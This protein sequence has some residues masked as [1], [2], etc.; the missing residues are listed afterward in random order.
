MCFPSTLTPPKINEERHL[1]QKNI[2]I[3]LHSWGFHV[4]FSRV[5]IS[6]L[7]KNLS[8]VR[9]EEAAPLS[10]TAWDGGDPGE[11]RLKVV[12]PERVDLWHIC[13]SLC[14]YTYYMYHVYNVIQV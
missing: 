9:T 12:Q 6:W 10:W 8:S 4:N 1:I 5:Y 2:F 11:I 13:V 3:H 14:I 7:A